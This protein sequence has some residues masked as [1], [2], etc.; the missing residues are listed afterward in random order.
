MSTHDSQ[1]TNHEGRNVKRLREILGIK[2]ETLA[3]ELGINQQKMS[4]IEQKEHIEDDMMAE[5]AKILK[6]PVD[7]IRNF[8]E[9]AVYN[10]ILTFNDNSTMN[11]HS[12]FN[13]NCTINPIDKWAEALEENKRLYERLLQSERE[14]V[15]ILEKLLPAGQ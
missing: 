4:F 5:I 13:Y 2:Q 12:A 3:A 6:V 1:T 15:A 8:N 10:K 7:A 14:K 9:E 11:D